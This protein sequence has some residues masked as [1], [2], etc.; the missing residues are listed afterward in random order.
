MAEV[1]QLVAV[2]GFG[3]CMAAMQGASRCDVTAYGAKN[4]GSARS[5]S[6][7]RAELD[8]VARAQ[9]EPSRELPGAGTF[10]SAGESSSDDWKSID[11]PDRERK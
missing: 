1:R 4:D 6:A 9:I 7:I 11:S 10:L 2:A 5:T 3:I 8:R